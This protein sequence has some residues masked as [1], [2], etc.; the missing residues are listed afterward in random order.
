MAEIELQVDLGD[1]LV[2]LGRRTLLLNKRAA[3]RA[4]DLGDVEWLE[5]TTPEDAGD[6]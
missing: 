5:R 1:M 4:K 2:A 3:G 6:G